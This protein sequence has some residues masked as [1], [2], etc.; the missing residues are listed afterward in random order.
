MTKP[1]YPAVIDTLGKL[2]DHGMGAF[3]TCPTCLKVGRPDVRDIDLHKLAARVG[4]DWCFINRRW[5]VKCA[6]CGEPNV[7]VR[8]AAPA[9]SH[10]NVR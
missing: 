1:T 4:R 9:P 5:P 3:T 10:P 2:I 8:I 6:T 7:K